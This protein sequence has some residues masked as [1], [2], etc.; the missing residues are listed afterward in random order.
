[1]SK[2]KVAHR[3]NAYETKP[4]PKMAALKA[5][6]ARCGGGAPSGELFVR[7]SSATIVCEGGTLHG[8]RPFLL[9]E[10]LLPARSVE[11]QVEPWTHKIALARRLR[12]QTKVR[13]RLTIS[14]S[15]DLCC[16]CLWECA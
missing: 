1:M 14:H 16:L 7:V 12:A 11:Q 4:Q 2:Y 8:A 3:R 5:K 9:H 13:C 15:C 10:L 6:D